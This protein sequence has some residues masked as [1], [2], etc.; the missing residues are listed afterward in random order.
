MNPNVNC[1]IHSIAIL[2]S[3]TLIPRL[4]LEVTYDNTRMSPWELYYGIGSPLE[5]GG[6]SAFV[7]AYRAGNDNWTVEKWH[8]D[9]TLDVKKKPSSDIR[10][11]PLIP[12]D[13][14]KNG[15]ISS[16]SSFIRY[17]WGLGKK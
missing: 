16:F 8:W 6:E 15:D 9:D 7:H 1:V 12:V 4:L 14:S 17:K 11:R 13:A 3:P 10:G 5:D 2:A